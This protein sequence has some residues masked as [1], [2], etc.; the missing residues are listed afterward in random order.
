LEIIGINGNGDWLFGTGGSEL[1][2]I[3]GSNIGEAGNFE[4]SSLNFTFVISWFVR[5]GSFSGN[6]VFFNVLESLVHKSSVTS[7][8]SLFGRAVN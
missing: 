1:I 7:L 5:V 8:V 3:S 2:N 4:S 6:S